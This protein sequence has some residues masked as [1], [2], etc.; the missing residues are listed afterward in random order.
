M[1]Y[2]H[3]FIP[4]AESWNIRVKKNLRLSIRTPTQRENLLG[5]G[6]DQLQ[7]PSAKIHSDQSTG[8]DEAAPVILECLYSL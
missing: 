7:V 4:A 6:P 5:I 8:P 1:S 2:N 3:I